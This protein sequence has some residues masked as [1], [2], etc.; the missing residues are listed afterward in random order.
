MKKQNETLQQKIDELEEKTSCINFVTYNSGIGHGDESAK[1]AILSAPET[2]GTKVNV[3]F[4][5]NS[6]GDN[7][8]LIGYDISRLY[9]AYIKISYY[10]GVK[11][12]KRYGDTWNISS[13]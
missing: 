9:T 6:N 4:V 11:Y 1:A 12:Y 10:A 13:L 7:E 2:Y 3:I 5:I 8:I